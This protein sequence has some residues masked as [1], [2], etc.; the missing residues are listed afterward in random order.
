MVYTH[1][2]F[3]MTVHSYLQR[4]QYMVRECILT[5]TLCRGGPFVTA[6]PPQGAP[7]SSFASSSD[8][9]PSQRCKANK[10]VRC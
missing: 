2:P 4:W 6:P 3:R 7:V 10:R 5:C 8:G 9:D 1:H